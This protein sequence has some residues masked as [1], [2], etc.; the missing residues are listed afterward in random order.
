MIKS[1]NQYPIHALFSME[2]NIVYRIPRYQREYS[3]QKAQW[4]DLFQDLVEAEGAHFL[5]TII[6]LNQ[7]KDAVDSTVLELIDGQQRAT[8]LSLLL[9]AI[10][11]VLREHE[12]ELD[13]NGQFAMISLGKR[14]VLD[15]GRLRVTPQTQG[16]NLDDYRR[17]L[18]LAGLDVDSQ[19]QPYFKARKVYKCYQYFRTAI[20]ELA[21]SDSVGPV[22]AARR[23]LTTTQQAILVKI[24]VESHA[25]AFVLFESLNNR[26]MALTPV[27]LIKNHLLAASAG[28]G[29][30]VDDAFKLWN[31]MLTNLG[32]SYAIQ[33]RFLRHF[34]N[35][36]KAE[37][38]EVP[39]A[40]VATKSKLIRIYEKL[41]T[42]DIRA[43]ME[44]L[45]AASAVYGRIT[46]VTELDE[47]TSLDTAFRQLMR[48]QGAPSYILVMWLLSRRQELAVSDAHL[49]RV[50]RLLTSFFVRRNLTGF[51]QTYA[52]PKLFMTIVEKLDG[53]TGDDVVARIT[54][55]L[56]GVSAGDAEFR[57]RLDGPV[58]D[59][60]S[61]VVRFILVALAED[62][63][64]KETWRDLWI[65]EKGHYTF[66][67][68]HVLP[69]GRN[70]PPA[71]V[72]MLGGPE[73]AAAA[74]EAHTHRLGN[75]TITAYN[76]T[77]GNKSFAEKRDRKDSH[78]R[79]IGYRNGLAL[80]AGLWAKDS[81]TVADIDA[82]TQDL[83]A[84]VIA[85]FP[86]EL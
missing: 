78:G 40:Q 6:T 54:R 13:G 51:P 28:D 48:A 25:D 74:Q 82:R 14:L 33:E 9:A 30:D 22:D 75:L 79:E 73:A 60:N 69:Q 55:D 43:R 57:D 8:T 29:L 50:V 7:T 85:R 67:I 44:E 59:E 31:E 76:S 65:Q 24:E 18:T 11:S 61:D 4:E 5:G 19:Q 15:G 23:V 2:S 39:N 58:Y 81:W 20:S 52:L 71:W 21:E 68:E 80:N 45:V 37:L 10:Y 72:Q 27:D 35:A 46:C 77:L 53:V 38:P 17:V 26:G 1:A 84:Q 63:M 62:A 49:V 34:Y 83:A 47:P 12:A 64:T 66:T 42:G 41:L 32:D 56:V 16:K 3:W 86:L 36:F 70:L